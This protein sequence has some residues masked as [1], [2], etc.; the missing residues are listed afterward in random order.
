MAHVFNDSVFHFDFYPLFQF[1]FY[2][3]S[4]FMG[5]S[6]LR[7]VPL[8]LLGKLHVCFTFFGTQDHIFR[9]TDATKSYRFVFKKFKMCLEEARLSPSFERQLH[10]RT[11]IEFPGVTR[12]KLVDLVPDSLSTHKTVFQDIY[13]P[14]AIFIFCRDKQIA[15]GTYNFSAH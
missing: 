13:L 12:L 7:L 11:K 2:I 15:S 4:N 5:D 1:P 8:D 14:E 10:S 9:K 3:G 6:V